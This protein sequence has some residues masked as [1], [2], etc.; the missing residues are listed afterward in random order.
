MLNQDFEL[1]G[2]EADM[3]A[4]VNKWQFCNYDADKVAFPRDCGISGP[5]AGQWSGVGG[6]QNVKFYVKS[7]F[8]D[9]CARSQAIFGVGDFQAKYA[10][11]SCSP[12]EI[13]ASY[14]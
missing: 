5:V 14:D 7:T 8:Y 13:F 6:Q 12:A 10:L 1:Y 9:F 4:G 2:S 11:I 3:N